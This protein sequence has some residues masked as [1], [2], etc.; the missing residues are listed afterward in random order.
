[1]K[2]IKDIDPLSKSEPSLLLTPED[3]VSVETGSTRYRQIM[4][5]QPPRDCA[6]LLSSDGGSFE[7]NG[8]VMKPLIDAL[9]V[10]GRASIWEGGLG[11]KS[12]TFTRHEDVQT[13]GKV[14][15]LDAC[16]GV[17]ELI[18]RAVVNC[19]QGAE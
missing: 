12:V 13:S 1:M 7:R 19:V 8:T 14:N 18:K 6:T 17:H 15:E 2:S 9:V 4:R 3:D 5:T 11:L 10:S 16:P